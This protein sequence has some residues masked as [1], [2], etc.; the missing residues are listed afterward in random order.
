MYIKTTTISA[1][2]LEAEKACLSGY[3]QH[4]DRGSF[5]DSQSIFRK[6]AFPLTIEITDPLNFNDLP[7]GY[8]EA[9]LC[10]YRDEL[11]NGYW[12]GE[13]SKAEY[14]YGQ[15][16]SKQMEA[17]LDVLEKTPYTNQA[18]LRIGSPEDFSMQNPPC[19]QTIQF[20]MI[21]QRLHVSV[22]FRSNDI[23]AA[24]ITNHGGI[25]LLTKDIAEYVAAEVGHYHYFC[26]AAH[27]YS[28]SL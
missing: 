8:T 24:F 6:Q 13:N 27:I 18:V 19:L 4:I 23:G 5:A 3:I 2:K 17:I 21:G 7:L 25:A 22:V 16:I 10:R 26:P 11:L 15:I 1:A 12:G 9:G 20:L 28:Y 14:T